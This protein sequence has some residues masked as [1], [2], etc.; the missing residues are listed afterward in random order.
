LELRGTSRPLVREGVSLELDVPTIMI[1]TDRTLLMQVLRNLLTNALKF[2]LHGS[3]LLSA[4]RPNDSEVT[5]SVADT[6]IGIAPA[7]QGKIFEEFFQ[8]RGSHQVSHKGTGLGLPYARR[9]AQILGGTMQLQSE[10]GRGSVFSVTLPLVWQPLLRAPESPGRLSAAEAQ[11]STITVGTA[12]IIDDDD[13]FRA[14][15]RGMLQGMA[16]KIIEARGGV[17]GLKIMRA[18]SP[19]VAFIDLRMPDMDGSEVLAEMHADLLLRSIPVVVIT[20]AHLTP[21]T[22]IT[23][24]AAIAVLSKSD[25]TREAVRVALADAHG[26]TRVPL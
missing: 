23:L 2:T 20:S 13:A 22:R 7:D 3:V 19:D 25:V 9:V 21:E 8:V 12:L 15:L 1:D 10:P 24:H 5:I 18:A 11:V 26:L 17:E 16:V 4:M 14:A 6:G